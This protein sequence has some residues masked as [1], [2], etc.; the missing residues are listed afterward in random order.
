NL[1]GY[2]QLTKSQLVRALGMPLVIVPLTSLATGHIGPQQSGSASA[3]Y[4]MFRNLGGSIG[5]AVLATQLDLREKLHSVRLGEAVNAFNPATSERLSTLTQQFI[6]RGAETVAAGQQALGAMAGTVR[7]EAYVMAYGDCFY[8][9][10]VLLLAMVLP[11]WL[12]KGAK[13]GA[14]AAH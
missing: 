14:L 5:I 9:L 12:C 6:A 1:T 13:G 11:I 8:L 4:N 10:G 3:L 7:R 2:D